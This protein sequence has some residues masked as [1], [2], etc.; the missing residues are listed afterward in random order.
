MAS[1]AV[2]KAASG[3]A[4]VA[5]LDA[6]W[7]LG[8]DLHLARANA[9]SNLNFR[10]RSW[11]GKASMYSLFEDT[12]ARSPNDVAYV[13][14]GRQTTWGQAQTEV[15]RIANYL[16]SSGLNPGDRIA[17]FMGNCTAYVLL[18]LAALSI[19]VVPAFINN[20]L[21]GP[22]LAHCVKVSRARLVIYEP[23][24]ESALSEVDADL[25]SAGHL[26]KYVCFDDGVAIDEKTAAPHAVQLKDSEYFGP[27]QLAAQSTKAPNPKLREAIGPS[28]VSTLIFTSGTTGLP[29]AALCSHGRI[30]G[31]CA[32]WPNVN[33]FNK[34]DRIYTPMPLYHSSAAFLCIGASWY[35]GSTVIIGR[36]FSASRYWQ[37]VRKYDATVVQYIG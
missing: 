13:Y 1:S 37:E 34:N 25:R 19:N 33:G 24:L 31:A 3:L 28:D 27:Q 30:G 18:W 21:R 15:H 11:R 20:G 10:L 32:M 23:Q 35:S 14:E 12:A 7:G 26:K 4:A 17:L 29:K 9:K 16:L 6:K 36:K 22:A 5:Y 2:L 8:N